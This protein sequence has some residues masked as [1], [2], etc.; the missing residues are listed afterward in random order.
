LIGLDTDSDVK[1]SEKSAPY[2][3]SFPSFFSIT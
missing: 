2:A 1:S 3:S